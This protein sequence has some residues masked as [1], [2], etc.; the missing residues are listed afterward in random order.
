MMLLQYDCGALIRTHDRYRY[1]YSRTIQI[2][3]LC[4]IFNIEMDP[5]TNTEAHPFFPRQILIFSHYFR[6]FIY[7]ELP[8]IATA[9]P[10]YKGPGSPNFVMR[11]IQF[12]IFRFH[13]IISSS[14]CRTSRQRPREVVGRRNERNVA[15]E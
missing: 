10:Y 7:I 1:I 11:R 13:L 3:R 9:G 6:T 5:P 15:D 4:S 8:S 14:R 2:H 12:L